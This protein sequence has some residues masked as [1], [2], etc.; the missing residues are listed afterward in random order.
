MECDFRNW[1]LDSIDDPFSDDSNIENLASM[2]DD[3]FDASSVGVRAS[4]V[5]FVD[6]DDELLWLTLD[7]VELRRRFNKNFFFNSSL[8]VRQSKTEPLSALIIYSNN[9]SDNKLEC[10]ELSA[11]STLV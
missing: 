10:L 11:S 9:N 6:S 3:V 5:I 1:K 7:V 4:K 8:T 2:S